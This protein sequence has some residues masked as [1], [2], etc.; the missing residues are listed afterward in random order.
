MLPVIEEDIQHQR[1]FGAIAEMPVI[2]RDFHGD[3]RGLRCSSAPPD[4]SGGVSAAGHAMAD[5]FIA[6]LQS[7]AQTARVGIEP[8][9]KPWIRFS[10]GQ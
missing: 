2:D 4:L 6:V 7:R 10:R 9:S 8:C 3:T 5:R 1:I